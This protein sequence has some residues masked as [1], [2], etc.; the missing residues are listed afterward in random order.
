MDKASLQNREKN[1]RV[2][3]NL[4]CGMAEHLVSGVIALMLTPFLIKKLGIELYGMYPIV[5]ELSAVFGIL[6]G[7]INSTSGRY[8]AVEE[9]RGSGVAARQYFA[10][11]FF[12][13]AVLGIILLLP[14]GLVTAF[15]N[16]VFNLPVGASGELKIFMILAFASVTVDALASAFGCVYYITNRLDLRSAQQLA[17]A[18]L[19]ALLLSL[20]L[21]LF[22][23]SLVGVGVAILVSGAVGALIQ[24]FV[25]RK[26]LPSFSLSV[27]D[28]SL[29]AVKRLAA[30]GLW[31]SFNRV[32]S[33][34]MC[35][36]MLMIANL[37]FSG[38]A[39]GLYSVAF[40][41]V[42]ALLGVIMALAA[43]F[44]PVS[45]KCFARG[46]RNR[47]RDSLARDEKLIGCFAAVAVAV[48]V[49]FCKEFFTLWLGSEPNKILPALT[50]VLLLPILSA[51]CAAPIINVGMVMDRTRRLS[52]FFLCGGLATVAAALFCATCT[53]IGIMSLAA[54]S[55]AAQ[56]IW[57]SVAVPLFAGRVLECSSRLFFEPILRVFLAC[58]L[59][60]VVCL[61][62]DRISIVDGWGELAVAVG[63]AA[64]VSAVISFF[65][66]FYNKKE[67]IG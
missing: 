5:L 28:F 43:V 44:V 40:V 64:T 59:S 22:K 13:N 8:I 41:C 19:K 52:F 65:I 6:F 17:S 35:G 27:R 61:A 53:G 34:L 60:S 57:Y 38:R 10:S 55:C 62:I 49:A 58:G 29:P 25:A 47:L 51:A 26:L 16:R 1:K 67:R 24:I 45:A 54:V 31:Y 4:L 66:L 9:E 12:A 23:P 2:G 48:S 39:S 50:S 14:M 37:L 42:N 33:F 36:A 20:L 30:S 18:V 7:V 21:G 11:A 32:A 63:C 56:I 3:F 46:E 15:C